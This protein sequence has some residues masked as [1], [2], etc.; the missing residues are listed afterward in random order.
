MDV[1]DQVYAVAALIRNLL[2]VDWVEPSAVVE[3]VARGK[4]S[5]IKP[6]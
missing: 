1:G 2:R 5:E 6:L 3:A 4:Q